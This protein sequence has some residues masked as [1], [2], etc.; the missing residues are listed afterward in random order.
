VVGQTFDY[1]EQ[2]SPAVLA[3]VPTLQEQI[4]SLVME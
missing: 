4:V 2:L 1:S 3:A